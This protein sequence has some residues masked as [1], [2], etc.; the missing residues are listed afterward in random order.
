MTCVINARDF[1][2]ITTDAHRDRWTTPAM[3]A[4]I[5]ALAG[6]KVAITTDAHTG[7]TTLGATLAYT[8]GGKVLVKTDELPRGTFFDL[9][10]VGM[11]LPLEDQFTDSTKW[12]ARELFRQRRTAAQD[13]AAAFLRERDGRNWGELE[14][15]PAACEDRFTVLYLPKERAPEGRYAG[16]RIRLR[17]E[18]RKG[19]WHASVIT[20]WAQR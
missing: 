8:A 4:V 18:E 2:A 3:A 15:T 12:D 1:N 11:I 9:M 17:M 19:R 7:G 10:D 5:T 6:R 16:S 20:D 13:A 14:V